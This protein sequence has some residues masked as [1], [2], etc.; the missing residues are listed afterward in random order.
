MDQRQECVE[1]DPRFVILAKLADRWIIEVIDPGKNLETDPM[2]VGG[3]SGNP[4]I[5]QLTK[6]TKETVYYAPLTYVELIDGVAH[7]FV[8][9]GHQRRQAALNNGA[10]VLIVHWMLN[11]TT[12]QQALD[13]GTSANS[14]RHEL[15]DADILSI[16]RAGSYGLNRMQEITSVSDTQLRRLERISRHPELDVVVKKKLVTVGLLSS[17]LEKCQKDFDREKKFVAFVVEKVEAATAAADKAQQH[18]NRRRGQKVDPV[19]K[20][21]ANAST[22]MRGIDWDAVKMALEKDDQPE[23]LTVPEGT[24]SKIIGIRVGDDLEWLSRIAIYGTGQLH[25]EASVEDLE[26]LVKSWPGIA[27]K[28]AAIIKRKKAESQPPL[29]SDNPAAPEREIKPSEDQDGEFDVAVPV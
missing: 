16:F 7:M 11:W 6:S 5:T 14:I 22:H 29:P 8:V 10:K 26:M 19:L 3:R 2:F 28:L 21:N 9:D 23:K 27:K 4:D 18:I 20:K 1:R 15:T 24:E 17:C 13:A 12:K 25:S